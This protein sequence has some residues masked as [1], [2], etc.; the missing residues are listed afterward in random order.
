VSEFADK[1]RSLGYLSGGRTRNTRIREGRHHPETGVAY[2][3]TETDAGR[4]IEHNTK[5]DRVD[6]VVTP[7]TVV[8]TRDQLKG[9]ADAS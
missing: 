9:Q 5:D 7:Q 4:T 6:V 1:V 3:V 8:V 2:K